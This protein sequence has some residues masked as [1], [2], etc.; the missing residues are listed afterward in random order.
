MSGRIGSIQGIMPWYTLIPREQWGVEEGSADYA[1][2]E[3]KM[4][5]PHGDRRQEIVFIGTDLKVDAI[6][7]ALDLCRLTK[8]E[9]KRYKFYTDKGYP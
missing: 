2:I 4:A 5:E 7:M 1:T 8:K 6:T 9:L 3:S